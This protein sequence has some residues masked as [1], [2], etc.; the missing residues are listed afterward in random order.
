MQDPD[1]RHRPEPVEHPGLFVVGDYLFDS[2]LNGVK[3][4]ADLVVEWLQEEIEERRRLPFLPRDDL[5]TLDQGHF[6]TA[7]Q[8]LR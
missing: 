4:S 7:A 6:L 5:D 1:A 3:D 2:T 8:V